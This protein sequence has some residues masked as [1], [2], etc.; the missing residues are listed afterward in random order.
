MNLVT[1]ILKMHFQGGECNQLFVYAWCCGFHS[2]APEL[3]EA[4]T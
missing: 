2:A 4:Y 3:L 1:K